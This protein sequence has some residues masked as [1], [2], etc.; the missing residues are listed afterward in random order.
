MGQVFGSGLTQA[1]LIPPGGGSPQSMPS[2]AAAMDQANQALQQSGPALSG[3]VLNPTVNSGAGLPM[4]SP[5]PSFFQAS[6]QIN[7]Q[8]GMPVSPLQNPQM[9]K[10]G[11]LLSILGLGLRGAMQG[12]ATQSE[13]IAASGGHYNPG[14]GPSFQA[15]T[16]LPFVDALRRQ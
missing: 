12:L 1:N 2:T 6:S 5:K 4:V 13:G 14:I 7:P 3:D 8:T 10:A 16:Q 9:T 11:K 15:A